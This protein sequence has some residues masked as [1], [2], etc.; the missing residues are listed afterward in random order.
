LIV[1]SCYD[2]TIIDFT[3]LGDRGKP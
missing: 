3:S 1:I 2:V